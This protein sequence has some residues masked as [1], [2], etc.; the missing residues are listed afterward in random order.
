M[1]GGGGD[2]DLLFNA[3]AGYVK[4]EYHG[5]VNAREPVVATR[6]QWWHLLPLILLVALI[7]AL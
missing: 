6:V 4:K 3:M 2:N 5:F 7:I 1:F